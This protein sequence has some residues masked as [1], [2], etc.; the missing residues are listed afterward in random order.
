MLA[1]AVELL[2]SG[3]ELH[4]I[5]SHIY[6]LDLL[7][8]ADYIVLVNRIGNVC[9]SLNIINGNVGTLFHLLVRGRFYCL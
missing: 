9:A 2:A 7:S 5:G 1:S 4:C 3:S 8:M 6:Q